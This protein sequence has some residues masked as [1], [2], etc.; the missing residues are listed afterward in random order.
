M[1]V[2][3]HTHI[4]PDELAR[5]TIPVMYSR[6]KHYISGTASDGTLHG[7]LE[8]MDRWGIDISVAQPVV[9]RQAQTQNINRWIKEAS[10]NNPGRLVSFGSIYPHTDDYKRD[11]SLVLD[12]GLKGL[13]FH[14]EYQDFTVDDSRMLKIYDYALS[15]G[16]ILMFHAGFDPSCTPPYKSSPRQ[17]RNILDAMKGGDIVAAHLGGHLQW[18]DVERYLAGR[19]IYLDMSMGFD[20]YPLEQFLRIVKSHGAD[21]ILFASDSPWSSA[22]KEIATLRSLPL[23]KSETD[24]ILGLNALRLL[25][26]QT[27]DTSVIKLRQA[28][29]Q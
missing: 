3:F 11:I 23:T 6:V 10:D 22:G 28:V 4:F 18:D 14:P 1:I 7:L 8:N 25:G 15:R 5:K 9:T 27:A 20:Y 24:K 16:L 19:S 21:K 13:K 29:Y 26:L 17:F 12:L 2:D